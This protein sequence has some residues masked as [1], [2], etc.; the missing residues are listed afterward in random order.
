MTRK[1]KVGDKVIL[2]V[3]EPSCDSKCSVCI[4]KKGDVGVIHDHYKNGYCN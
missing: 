3:K 2:V 4:L 1:F